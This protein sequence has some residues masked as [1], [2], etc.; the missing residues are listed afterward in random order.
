MQKKA[1]LHINLN[2]TSKEFAMLYILIFKKHKSH[3]HEI[4]MVKNKKEVP[5][6]RNKI[7]MLL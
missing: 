7:A 6:V 4:V 5:C 3:T 1:N 2:E